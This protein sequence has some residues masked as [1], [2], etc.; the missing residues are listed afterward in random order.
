[1]ENLILDKDK[2]HAVSQKVGILLINLGT[3]DAPTAKAVRPYLKQF[4]SDARVVEVPKFIWWFILNGIILPFRSSAS[5]KK[6]ASVWMEQ[7]SGSGA[8]LFVH[9]NSQRIGLQQKL[10]SNESTKDVKV[11]LAM[12]YGNPSIEKVMNELENEGVNRLLVLPLYPQYSA[13]TTASSFDA[14]FEVHSKKRNPPALRMVKNYHDHPAYIASLVKQ[15]QDFWVIHGTPDFKN[16]DKLVMSFHGVPK[17]T[18]LRGDPYHCECYKT[19]RL[20]REALGLSGEEAILSFQSR[21]GKAEWLKPYTA[22]L[23]ESLG[24]AKTNRLDIFCPGFPA[25]CLETLEEIAMEGKEIFTHAGGQSYNVIPCLN[26]QE[27]WLDGLHTIALENIA[28]WQTQVPSTAEIA[29]RIAMGQA[30][31]KIMLAP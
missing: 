2:A 15:V 21:F 12:R 10:A 28:G 16:G 31:E 3:P 13:T 18:L 22:P 6:Y 26:N 9:S 24:K 29:N 19:G 27:T 17:R 1:M 30:A 23:L 4:L 20:L 5:A 11:A 25:D 8:P 7:A 14:V